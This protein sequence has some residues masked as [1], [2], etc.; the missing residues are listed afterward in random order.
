M[1]YEFIWVES[2]NI[3]AIYI[4]TFSSCNYGFW[5]WNQSCY[6]LKREDRDREEWC[7]RRQTKGSF[8]KQGM[9]KSWKMWEISFHIH[10]CNACSLHFYIQLSLF[11]RRSSTKG[12]QASEK[13]ERPAEST[14]TGKLTADGPLE[15]SKT[16]ETVSSEPQTAAQ[17]TGADRSR[18]AACILLWHLLSSSVY[19][20]AGWECCICGGHD[21]NIKLE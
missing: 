17:T 1:R 2:E 15:S 3:V 21:E 12:N 14:S 16:Q 13:A 9:T 18:S 20:T 10:V 5:R 19:R 4:F 6:H 11:K 8:W 7:S